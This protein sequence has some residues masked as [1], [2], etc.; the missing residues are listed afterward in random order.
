MDVVRLNDLGDLEG[1]LFDP[2]NATVFILGPSQAFTIRDV[3]IIDAFLRSGGRVILADEFGTGN[4]LLEG[5]GLDIRFSG[6]VLMDPLFNDM[7]LRLPR[8]LNV[9]SSGVSDDV[10]ELTLNIPTVLNHTEDLNVLAWS[11]SFSF[12]T[13]DPEVLG[14]VWVSGSFPIAVEVVVGEG[15]LFVISDSSL[16]INGMLD[17]GDNRKF[18]LSLVGGKVLIDESHSVQSMLAR[19][20]VMLFQVYSFLKLTEIRYGLAALCVI[21]VFKV[22]WRTEEVEE[23]VDPVEE[24]LR[25]HPEWDRDLLMI[26][27]EERG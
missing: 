11:T 14:A 13:S 16:F 3:G 9:T 2:S 22:S 10:E 4:E 8:V 27:E 25:R 5:L 21:V 17:R 7:N 15:S 23:Q 20:R 26:L 24:A 6:L 18:L 1:V 19:M 12:L